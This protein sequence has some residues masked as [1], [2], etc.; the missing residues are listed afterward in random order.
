MRG[1]LDGYLWTTP[2]HCEFG[3]GLAIFHSTVKKTVEKPEN[4]LVIFDKRQGISGL[5]LDPA[6]FLE[7]EN[8][9][10]NRH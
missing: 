8:C 3:L 6:C 5:Q 4:V 7:L 1:H 10:T 9:T 2:P